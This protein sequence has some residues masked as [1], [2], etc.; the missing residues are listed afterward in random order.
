MRKY[1]V[2]VKI[3]DDCQPEPFSKEQIKEWLESAINEAGV[4]VEVLS[5]T[6]TT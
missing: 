6:E 1:I 4:T 5:L 3:L 2:V